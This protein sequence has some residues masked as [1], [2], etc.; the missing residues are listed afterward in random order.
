[1]VASGN[2][3]TVTRVLLS[4][5]PEH[6]GKMS[7]IYDTYEPFKHGIACGLNRIL[8]RDPM[9]KLAALLGAQALV[10]LHRRER[11]CLP[12]HDWYVLLFKKREIFAT[13]D[14]FDADVAFGR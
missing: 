6:D 3:P 14:S 2:F 8:I 1:M 12:L 5:I 7:Y 11:H 13:V 4:K 9:Q 10:P